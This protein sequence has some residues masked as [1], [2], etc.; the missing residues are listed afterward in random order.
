MITAA[1]VWII[2]WASGARIDAQLALIC[3]LAA[4]GVALLVGSIVS[5]TRASR[6]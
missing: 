6:R 2:A 1:G 4:G 5:G 3:L